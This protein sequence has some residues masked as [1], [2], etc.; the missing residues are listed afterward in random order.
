MQTLKPDLTKFTSYRQSFVPSKGIPNVVNR[1]KEYDKLQGPHIGLDS[2]YSKS[3]H[4]AQ[5]D[6]L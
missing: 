4:S 2:Q 6:K 3:Y 1:A 5:G